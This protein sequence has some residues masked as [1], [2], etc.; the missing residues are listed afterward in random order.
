MQDT[1]CNYGIHDKALLAV[2]QAFKTWKRYTRGSQRPVQVFIDHKNLVPFMSTKELT[3][4]QGRYQEFLSQYNFGIIYRPGR[5]GRNW[6]PSP[7]DQEINPQRE[8]R[9]LE[10][11]WGFNYQKKN[12]RTYKK[13]KNSRSRKWGWRNFRTR[14]KKT[15]DKHR[16]KTMKYKQ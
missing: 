3:Q 6:T 5:E 11:G 14:T 13:V 1:E 15:Y 16:T 4:R 7:E 8:R 9:R 10:N 2:I 12:T